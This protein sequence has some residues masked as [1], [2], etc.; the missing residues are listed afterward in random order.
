MRPLVICCLLFL[1]GLPGPSATN[2]PSARSLL[3]NEKT[4][5]DLTAGLSQYENLPKLTGKL[6]SGGSGLVTLLVNRWASEFATLYSD[7]V[8][9]I[10]GGGS[11]ASLPAFLAGK[12]D[13]MPMARPLLP[14]ELK[15][16][17]DKFGYEPAQIIVAQDAVGIYVNKNN[18]LAG[19]T[20]IQLDGIYSRDHKRGGKRAE[21]WADLGVTGPLAQARITRLALSSVHG[22]HEFFRDT[23]ML[24]SDYRF[25]GHFESLLSSLVQAVGADEAG[26]GFGSVMFGTERTRFVPLQTPNGDYL[27]PTYENTV[28]GRYPLARALRIVF[29]RKPD[30]SLNPVVREFLR[31]A[32]S[33]RGQRIIALAES[34]PLTVEQQQEALRVIGETPPEKPEPPQRKK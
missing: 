18:P 34:F 4:V 12:V 28:T 1:A 17:K 16:C 32:V 27:L 22:S 7:V 3:L 5:V 26:V 10:Q 13:L 30:G 31:F 8:L 29:R 23:V 19:L 9:D 6:V 25:G 21:F 14:D 2:F 24:G 33:R 11:V 20:L 15:Q